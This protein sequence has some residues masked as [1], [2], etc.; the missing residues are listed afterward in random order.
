MHLM[1]RALSL[2]L[3]S[4]VLAV[5]PTGQLEFLSRVDTQGIVQRAASTF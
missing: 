5:S 3:W 1:V 2:P 4:F